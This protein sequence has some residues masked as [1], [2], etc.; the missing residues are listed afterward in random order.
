[1]TVVDDLDLPRFDYTEPGLD[2]ER[3]HEVM[4][5]LREQSWIARTDLGFVVLDREAANFFL[6]SRSAE[7]PGVKMFELLGIT[8]GPL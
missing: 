2:G 3:F 5:A 6:K 1:M 7:F 4:R 8:D